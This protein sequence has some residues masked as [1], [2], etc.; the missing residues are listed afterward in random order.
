[1]V[2]SPN[3][4]GKVFLAAKKSPGRKAVAALTI[5]LIFWAVISVMT[6][7]FWYR[8][9]EHT[10]FYP[11]WVGARLLIFEGR[12]LYDQSTT[13]DIQIMIYGEQ[14]LPGEDQQGF[15]YPAHIIPMLAPFWLIPDRAIAAALWTG[16]TLTMMAWTLILLRSIWGKT[17]FIM[18]GLWLFWHYS[19]AMFFPSQFTAIP[20]AAVGIG[21]WAYH[22]RRDLLAGAVLAVGTI[23]P[24][25]V[26]IPIV[27]ILFLALRERRWRLIGSFLGFGAGW[28]LISVLVAGWW[29]PGWLAQLR[30]YSEY[31][32][33]SW[34]PRTAWE[35]S[36]IFAVAALGVVIISLVKMRWS[37]KVVIAASIVMGL[38]LLP[39]TLTHNLVL[40]L[41]PLNM[42]WVGKAR[43]MALTM[44]FLG[45]AF[46]LGYVLDPEWLFWWRWQ[47][48]LVPFLTLL[49]VNAASRQPENQ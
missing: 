43:R 7:T 34:P 2:K 37:E 41:I 35:I 28:F 17:P 44:W 49:V 10:D 29:I 22:T 25:L 33:F 39:Q 5:S 9:G 31:A 4:I 3:P 15:A 19:F 20:L 40:L 14:L 24:Q 12:D 21:Y 46:F 48:L 8:G 30:D 11:R 45:W 27:V 26:A 13:R 42:V 47:V 1:M 16:L 23:K 36:P 6:Y 32:P 38:L 18:I